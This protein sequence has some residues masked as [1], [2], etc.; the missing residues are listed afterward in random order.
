MVI[1]VSK[2]NIRSINFGTNERVSDIKPDSSGRKVMNCSYFVRKDNGKPSDIA[3]YLIKKSA[4]V[5]NV[6]WKIWGCSDLSCF[7]TNM[8]AIQKKIGLNQSKKKFNNIELIDIDSEIV[9]RAKTGLV[10]M[11]DCDKEDIRDIVGVDPEKY[12]T[13]QDKKS[14]FLPDEPTAVSHLS[15]ARKKDLKARFNIP[16]GLTGLFT[17]KVEILPYKISD[18]LI[19][20][21]KIRVGDIRQDIKKL[22][23]SKEGALRIFEFANSWYF[24]SNKDQI[25]LAS[26]LS[27]KMKKNDILMIGGVEMSRGVGNVLSVLGFEKEKKFNNI[28]VKKQNLSVIDLF[29]KKMLLLMNKHIIAK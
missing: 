21:A 1:L 26:N 14:F 23:R 15:D 10:G 25:K 13:P 12:F 3:K 27:K 16:E 2:N 9:S 4:S 20:N 22:P 24:L 17:K 29:K 7:L 8:M 11:T 5:K 19:G 6:E 18:D 28:F